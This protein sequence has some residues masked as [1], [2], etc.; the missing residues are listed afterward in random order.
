[1]AKRLQA[2][3]Q[4]NYANGFDL[5]LQPHMLDLPLRLKKPRHIFVNSM[6]D[7]FHKDVPNEYI[8]RVFAVMALCPQHT[9]QVLTKRAERMCSYFKGTLTTVGH[10]DRVTCIAEALGDVA[11]V[12]LRKRFPLPNVWLGVSVENQKTADERISFLLN[13]PAAVRWLSCE[14]LLEAV[15]LTTWLS[16]PAPKALQI[17]SRYYGQ[18]GFDPLGAQPQINREPCHESGLNWI[19][20]GGESGGGAR[21]MR[22]DWAYLLRDQCAAA[23]VPFFFK[24]TGAVLAKQ[25]KLKDKKGGDITELPL[26]LQIRQMP[27][28][29]RTVAA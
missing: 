23:R 12:E 2:M 11:P 3:G 9:F 16:R 28:V 17:L 19:V 21:L 13:T 10:K 20:V 6:S 5:T 1:M 4:A 22:P 29:E 24:Q 26:D 15:D 18:Q 25:W 7:L 27:D 14:P 8:D